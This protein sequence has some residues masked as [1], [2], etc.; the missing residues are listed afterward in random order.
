MDPFSNSSD[1][2]FFPG[3]SSPACS[4]V[5]PAARLG[6]M[7]TGGCRTTSLHSTP[8]GIFGGFMAIKLAHS[9]LLSIS[10]SERCPHHLLGTVPSLHS[11]VLC[12]SCLF[13]LFALVLAGLQPLPPSSC[14]ET[15]QPCTLFRLK[16][17]VRLLV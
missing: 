13:Q 12:P 4:P 15:R 6:S 14:R 2:S 16:S 8:T 3:T 10:L 7:A 9:L 17:T 1:Q 5:I 11:P